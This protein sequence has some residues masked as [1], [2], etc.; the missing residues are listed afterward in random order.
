MTRA[1]VSGVASGG[2]PGCGRVGRRGL[3]GR[4]CIERCVSSC[5]PFT[6]GARDVTRRRVASRGFGGIVAHRRRG[7]RTR[8]N[9]GRRLGDE[10]RFAGRESEGLD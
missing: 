6:G 10:S 2:L 4:C 3:G 1:L 5:S 9:V 7:R 8:R